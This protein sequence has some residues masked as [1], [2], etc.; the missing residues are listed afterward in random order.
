MRMLPLLLFLLCAL[1]RIQAQ[2]YSLLIR[3][4]YVIDPRTHIHDTLDIAVKDDLIARIARNIDPRQAEKVIDAR[5]EIVCPGLIDMH[6]HVFYGTH[7]DLIYAGGTAAV[8]PDNIAPREGVTTVVDAG[9]S[10]WQDF[11]VFKKRVIDRSQTR[12]LAFLNIVG[13]GMRGNPYEQDTCDMN[14]SLAA[15]EARKY[16]DV[17]VGFKVAH[18]R[19]GN[20]TPVDAA[21]RAG[22][23]TGL[24]VMV[25][26]GEHIPLMPIK[27]L[28][29]V[30]LRP[31]DI[32][33]HCF[34][35]LQDREPIVNPATRTLKPFVRTARQKGIVFDVGYGDI[36][37]AFSQA[38]PALNSGFLPNSISTDIH[39]GNTRNGLLEIMDRFLAIGLDTAAVITM[40]TWNPAREIHHEQLGHLSE[41]A[42]ADITLL[43][44]RKGRFIFSDHTGHR[45]EG[46]QKFECV[47]TV[48]DGKIVYSHFIPK[49]TSHS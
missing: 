31:G 16:P 37:F 8:I 24:P 26:F 41:G 34:A 28:F 47:L 45:V 29:L 15:A 4:G 9:S 48:R 36:S 33:T 19:S 42:I 5:G 35:Q 6:T 2:P 1:T 25:D 10:G 3:G 30:H 12:V 20:W 32:F 39:R 13:A 23:R 22:K 21:V 49:F 46:T 40:T 17:I 44:L 38:I 14:D 18:Y 11:D 43:R 7:P 27:Q